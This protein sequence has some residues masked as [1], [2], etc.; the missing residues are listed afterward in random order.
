MKDKYWDMYTQ[1]IDEKFYYNL[2]RNSSAIWRTV[3]DIFVYVTSFGSI[4]AWLIWPKYPLIWATI[5]IISQIINVVREFLPFSRRINALDFFM[6]ELDSLINFV[7]HTWAEIDLIKLDDVTI[8]ESEFNYRNQYLMLENKY[9][10]NVTYLN[11]KKF[12]NKAV[13]ERKAYF[14]RLY[15]IDGTKTVIEKESKPAAEKLQEAVPEKVSETVAE[16]D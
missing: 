3:I 1:F 7:D 10:Q 15:N 14:K 5:L 8:V 6:P 12:R 2:Y 16:K 13:E 4:A 11:S 9:L